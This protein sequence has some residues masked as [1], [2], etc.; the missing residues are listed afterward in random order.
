MRA[1]SGKGIT[2]KAATLKLSISP[3]GISTMVFRTDKDNEF[4][5]PYSNDHRVY[6]VYETHRD[7]ANLPWT[8]STDDQQMAA[9][10]RARV[11]GSGVDVSAA[12]GSSTGQL[13]TMRL[14]QSCNAE[15]ANFFGATSVSQVG[16]V[17]AAFNATLTRCNGVYE[18][19]LA[20]HLN[21]ISSTTSVIY[22]TA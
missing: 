2:D 3:E 14:A 15:Y 8:C 6:S 21:L 10:I 12:T 22:Y 5:E 1:F 11:Q 13:K 18:K 19:D 20:L 17:L 4:I 9:D 16:L 7:R